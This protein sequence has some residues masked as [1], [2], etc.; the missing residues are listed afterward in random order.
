MSN[1]V[2]QISASLLIG[3]VIGVFAGR[4][5]APSLSTDDEASR[6]QSSGQRPD[7]GDVA[8]MVSKAKKA[9]DSDDDFI[10]FL[11]V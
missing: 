5:T 1:R 2:V 11:I 7:I 6:A 9:I 3:L 8:R 4:W 10:T